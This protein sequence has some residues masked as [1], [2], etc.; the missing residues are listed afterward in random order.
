MGLRGPTTGTEKVG[1]PLSNEH[2]EQFREEQIHQ[3][4]E[5]MLAAKE[6]V[7]NET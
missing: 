7:K 4:Y 6:D 3:L 2:L 5:L 1:A